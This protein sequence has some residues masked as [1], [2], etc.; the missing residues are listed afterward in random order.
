MFKKCRGLNSLK[1][2]RIKLFRMARIELFK[3][4]AEG[5]VSKWRGLNCLDWRGLN[6]LKMCGTKSSKWSRLNC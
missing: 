2:A 4:D 3:N 6:C 5:T 1:M